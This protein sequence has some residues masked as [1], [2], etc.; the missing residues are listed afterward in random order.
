MS[1][2]TKKTSKAVASLAAK[3]LKDPN[4]SPTAKKLAGAALSQSSTTNQTGADMEKIASDVLKSDRYNDDTK[5]LAGAV[6]AQCNK[7]R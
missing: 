1:K 4:T 2:N 5:T 7:N 3:I 6:L